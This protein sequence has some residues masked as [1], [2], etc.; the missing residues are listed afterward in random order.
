MRIENA[1]KLDPSRFES[2]GRGFAIAPQD[3]S[4]RQRALLDRMLSG[5]RKT[6]PINQRIWMHNIEFAEVA[7]RFGAYVSAQAPMGAREKEICIL[8]V[9]RHWKSDFEWHWHEQLAHKHGLTREQTDA[10]RDGRSPVFETASEQVTHDIVRALFTD[11][12]VPDE[13]FERAMDALGRNAVL[14]L[15]GLAGLYSMIAHTI[16]LYRLRVPAPEEEGK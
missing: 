9:A 16:M 7:E 1:G 11:K 6:A 2:P 14:D 15:I 10:I 12:D 5:P 8:L 13:L 4:E 3:L